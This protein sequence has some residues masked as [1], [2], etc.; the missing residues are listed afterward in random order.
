MGNSTLSSE[1]FGEPVQRLIPTMHDFYQEVTHKHGDRV[2]LVCIH[3]PASFLSSITRGDLPTP[4][5]SPPEKY[6]RW[7]FN[8]ISHASHAVAASL[9]ASGIGPGMRIISFL[10]NGVEWHIMVRAALELN[11]LFAPL[12]PRVALN[13]EEARH[14]MAMIEPSAILVEDADIAEKLAL[15]AP[16]SFGKA[17]LKLFSTGGQDKTKIPAG[18][19]DFATFAES[20]AS[21]GETALKS[22][23]IDRKPE[24]VIFMFTTSGTT[25]LPKG[26]PYTNAMCAGMITAYIQ[27]SELG[28]D[29]NR[30]SL[31]H[32]ATSHI[33]GGVGYSMGFHCAGLKVVVPGPTFDAASSLKAIHV[34]RATDFPAVPALI[35]AMLANPYFEQV[36]TSCL[37]H[38]HLGA[39]TILPEVI[40]MSMEKLKCERASEAFGMTETGPAIVHKYYDLPLEVPDVVTSGIVLPGSKIRVCDPETNKPV[41]RGKP[42]ECHVGGNFIIR[43]YW[44]G[45]TERGHDA[46]YTDEHGLWIR[47]GDQAVMHENGE[48]QIVGRHKDMIIRGGENISPSAIESIILSKFDLVAEVVGVP[49]EIA[50]EIPIAVISRKSGQEVDVSKVRETLVKELGAAWVPEEIINVQ[51]LGIDDYPRTA[52][53]KVV[54][55]KLRKMVIENKENTPIVLTGTNTLDTLA[56]VWTKLLGVSP[57]TITPEIS[58][59]DW[60]DSLILARFSAVFMRETGM[61]LQLQ[62]LVDHPTLE[63]QAKLLAARGGSGVQSMTDMKPERDGPPGLYDM[64]HTHGEETRYKKTQE[65]A[66]ETMKP[67]GLSWEDVEDVIPMNGIQETFMKYRRPQSSNHRHAFLCKGASVGAVQEALEATLA[68][69]SMLRTMAMY[70]DSHT[71]LHLTIRPSEQWFSKCI[72]RFPLVKQLDDLAELVY[73][74]LELDHACFPGPMM[75]CIIAHVEETKC[76]GVVYMI[77]HSVFDAVSLGLFLDDFDAMLS[78]PT[79]KLKPHVPYKAWADSYYNLQSSPIAKASVDWQVERLR[80]I[81]KNPDSLFPR[82]RAPEMFKGSSKGWIDIKTGKP[83]P[84]RKALTENG[85]GVKGITGQGILKDI[86]GLK[87]KHSIEGSQIVKAALAVVTSRHTKQEYA[88]FGQSQAGRTWPFMLPWQANRMPPAMDVDGPAVQGTLNKIAINKSETVL[89]MLSRLQTEQYQI[90]RHAYAPM[91]QLVA[92]LNG[93]GTNVEVPNFDGKVKGSAWIETEG[94]E[95]DFMRNAFKRQIFNWLPVPPAFDFE[96]LEKVQ[97]ESRTD[98]CCLWNCIMLDQMT[99]M[100]NPTWD[101][102]QLYLEEVKG[103]LDEI[104]RLSEKFASEENWE[105]KIEEFI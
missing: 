63:G 88:L 52:T 3:Q 78:N 99:V 16:E 5:S 29:P 68:H 91:N 43:E 80:G 14:M 41:P 47:T 95:G 46:F 74:D 38:A 12:N 33:M 81:S 20:S 45:P 59:H 79:T 42:G 21:A 73:G 48:C 83:G 90:N 55:T 65:L 72:R 18:W 50:G 9:A 93:K 49:D 76:A 89:D 34:E 15:N 57:G 102:A 40:R 30:V 64:V 85:L 97:V 98:L 54:K 13:K 22:L 32:M 44:L 8:Q 10:N 84:P 51:S 61:L 35:Y 53:G 26:C 4:P 77:Q 25:N 60:A 86:Q 1:A 19:Q 87:V 6:L 27:H 39:T 62:D 94:G 69:H 75:R 100:I 17:P 58:I 11:C 105:K 36:D 96:R 31:C 70:Y 28:R 67:L 2:A 66:N 56:R 24:D 101:D 7:T 92:M 104:L 103:M 71:S 82:Q 37:K 23:K